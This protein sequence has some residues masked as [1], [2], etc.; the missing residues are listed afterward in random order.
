MGAA[1]QPASPGAFEEWL[2][3]M[4]EAA[5]ASGARQPLW[6]GLSIRDVILSRTL[7]CAVLGR[8]GLRPQVID[9]W[10]P[11]WAG[12]SEEWL[13]FIAAYASSLARSPAV[14]T[15]LGLCTRWPGQSGPPGCVSESA[16][17]AS[18][19][20]L[21]GALH[22]VGAGGACAAALF[23]YSS[24]LV[25]SPV[26]GDDPGNANRGLLHPDGTPKEAAGIW[27]QLARSSPAVRPL[28]S[29]FPLPDPDLAARS[30]EQVAREC[31]EAMIR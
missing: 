18:A 8:L 19:E 30:P 20:R 15:N 28:P 12:G 31:F 29:G 3:L 2:G 25:R 17:A 11:T 22:D 5:R 6:H 23:D 13:P 16:A 21:L 4:A 7:P 27:A 26:L 14:L 10:R 9:G 24:A 1:S